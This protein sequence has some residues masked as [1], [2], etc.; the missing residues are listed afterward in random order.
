MTLSHFAHELSCLGSAM[1]L[2]QGARNPVCPS[3]LRRARSS[4]QHST[5]MQLGLLCPRSS[6][7]TA[8]RRLYSRYAERQDAS[9]SLHHSPLD[10]WASCFGQQHLHPSGQRFPVDP[11]KTT[12]DGPILRYIWHLI[13]PGM[14]SLEI[15]EAPRPLSPARRYGP[16]HH[17]PGV[18]VCTPYYSKV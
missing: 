15:S 4:T 6:H 18:K 12:P 10:T 9:L 7:A 16:Q 17:H 3:V 2:P 13:Y 1:A 8:K 5:T 11:H 14:L